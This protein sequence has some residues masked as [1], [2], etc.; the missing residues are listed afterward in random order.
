MAQ[1]KT[2]IGNTPTASPSTICRLAV[3]SA[4]AGSFWLSAEKISSRAFWMM[5]DRPKVTSNGGRIS[6]P[7]VKLSRPRWS[8]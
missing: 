7:R 1:A 6:G 4:P 5:I 2:I 3:W 8:A